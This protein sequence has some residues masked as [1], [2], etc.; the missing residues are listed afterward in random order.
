MTKPCGPLLTRISDSPDGARSI[1]RN[2]QRSVRSGRDTN[3]PSPDVSLRSQETGQKVLVR[4]IRLSVFE[5]NPDHLV[6]GSYEPVPR[7]MLAGENVAFIFG[8][9]LRPIVKTQL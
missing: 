6:T 3:R 4:A 9:K 5:R 8:G 1:I 2:Q 7:T